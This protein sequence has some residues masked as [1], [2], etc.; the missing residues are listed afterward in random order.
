[1]TRKEAV[2]L[3]AARLNDAGLPDAGTDSRLLFEYITGVTVN[4]L[5]LHPEA[6]ISGEE[7]AEYMK[8][9]DRRLTHVPVQ[10]ITGRQE[11]MGLEFKVD[12]NVLIPR[13][14]TEVLVE[15]AMRQG[16]SHMNILD[17]C[18][19]SGCI[20]L[21]LMHYSHDCA[22]TGVDISDEALE[23]AGLNSERLGIP[24]RLVKSD[25][26]AGL[27]PRELKYDLIISNP[28]YIPT[29]VIP[30]LM[31]EVRDHEPVLALDGSPDGLAFYRRIVS[32][33]PEFLNMGGMLMFETGYD[34]ASAVKGLMEQRGFEDVT[35]VKDLSGNDRVVSGR[36]P[37][38]DTTESEYV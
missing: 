27:D 4:E 7:E 26:F 22:G 19:G 18:T 32:E 23:I 12:E 10:H 8:V 16:L 21:S 30:T 11:F 20:L 28:P 29:D 14:D 9:I 5:F 34:Q 37:A 1:M 38:M 36:W 2:N 33:S 25:L 3:A 35:V 31:E 13:F 6:E 17:M 15:E 24:V